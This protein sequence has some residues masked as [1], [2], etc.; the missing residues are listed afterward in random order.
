MVKRHDPSS[1]WVCLNKFTGK[2]SKIE[3]SLKTKQ[4]YSN[5]HAVLL[6]E[7]QLSGFQDIKIDSNSQETRNETRHAFHVI[8]KFSSK[9]KD[10]LSTS[11]RKKASPN[12]RSVKTKVK[13][14]TQVKNLRKSNYLH[15]DDTEKCGIIEIAK[16]VTLKS[17]M[18][19]GNFTLHG[20]SNDITNCSKLCCQD[21]LCDI[22]LIMTGRCY[23]VQCYSM[24]DCQSK[25]V[26]S[27]TV[28]NVIAYIDNP[29]K[30]LRSDRRNIKQ[31]K[32]HIQR[33][34]NKKTVVP[35]PNEGNK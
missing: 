29:S 16:N 8:K 22:A 12:R 10:E 14:E 17:G 19:A 25:N 28:D 3:D 15:K 34:N 11:K 9:R 27:K 5:E 13:S 32:H 21:Q 18:D 24:Q 4:P 30:K 31:A 23:T 7:T 2:S 1:Y 6:N 33:K 20:K 35:N 26:D